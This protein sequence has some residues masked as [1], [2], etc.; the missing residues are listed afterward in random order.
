MQPSATEHRVEVY[1]PYRAQS[2]RDRSVPLPPVSEI[3][4]TVVL[5]S[6]AGNC[7]APYRYRGWLVKSVPSRGKWR[8]TCCSRTRERLVCVHCPVS[9]ARD[10]AGTVM[11]RFLRSYRDR[12]QSHRTSTQVVPPARRGRR[13]RRCRHD[14][15]QR[16]HE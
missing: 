16:S 10:C 15:L 7:V 12:S 2:T 4:R 9:R 14:A 11:L 6:T 1:T 5:P 3:R 8:H 13:R